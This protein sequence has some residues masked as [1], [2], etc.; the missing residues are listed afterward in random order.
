MKVKVKIDSKTAIVEKGTTILEA[1]KSLGIEIPEICN[2]DWLEPITSCMVCVVKIQGR[3]GLVPSCGT[4]VWDGM[5]VITDSD[6]VIEARKNAIGLLLSEHSGDCIPP[7]ERLCKHGVRICSMIRNIKK[8]D[9][10]NAWKDLGLS[11]KNSVYPCQNCDSPCEKACRRKLLD[12]TVSIKLLTKY[13]FNCFNETV[14]GVKKQNKKNICDIIE[15]KKSPSILRNLN[16]EELNC[17]L[18]SANSIEAVKSDGCN[19][20]Y[21]EKDA[22]LESSRCL[23]CDC[24]A[25]DDCRL[26][27][28]ALDFGVKQTFFK[29]ERIPFQRINIS[30]AVFEQGKCIRCGICVRICEKEDI[31]YGFTFYRRGFDIRLEIPF[32]N[33]DDPGLKNIIKKCVK[34]CPTGALGIK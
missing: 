16:D 33:Y 26:K 12:S 1:A 30:D 29:G 21:G 7:C 15:Q 27:D 5:E 22:I 10:E 18:K 25:Q 23:D 4:S 28:M 3:D 11:K 9:L 20:V 2:V 13:L 8:G 24:V 19:H 17:F 31:R 14:G 32:K 34:N 6:E